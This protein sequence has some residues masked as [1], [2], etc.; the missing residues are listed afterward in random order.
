ME[1]EREPQAATAAGKAVSGIRSWAEDDRPREKMVLKG[2]DALSDT[3]LVAILLRTGHKP[4]TALDLARHLMKTA[5]H[6]L[7]RLSRFSLEELTKIRGLGRAKAIALIAAFELGRRKHAKPSRPGC[8]VMGSQATVEMLQPR[9]GDLPHEEFMVLLLDNHS[10][11]LHKERLTI[12]GMAMLNVDTRVIMRKALEHKASGMIVCHNHPSGD[13]EPSRA[14]ILFTEKLKGAAQ[15]LE[16][17]LVDHVILCSG[18][19]YS[20][21]DHSRI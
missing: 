20:F 14:D 16:I 5:G 18:G 17:R 4:D 11:L 2:T 12:G 21:A 1:S 19:Y 6:D 15:L 13:P 7:Q 3:E 10:R 9:M 8:V